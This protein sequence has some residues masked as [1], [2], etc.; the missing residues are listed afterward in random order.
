MEKYRILYLSNVMFA[1]AELYT[2]RLLHGLDRKKFK[3]FLAMTTP[4]RLPELIPKDVKYINV[5]I[6]NSTLRTAWKNCLII[7]RLYRFIRRYEID[8][9]STQNQGINSLYAQAAAR[10]GGIPAVETLQHSY[11]VR[12]RTDDFLIRNFWARFIRNSLVD[13]FVSL[14][15]YLREEQY[16]LWNVPQEKLFVNNMGVDIKEISPLGEESR[17]RV[18]KEFGLSNDNIILGFIGRPHPV[19]GLSKVFSLMS[20]LKNIIPE[21]RLLAVGVNI[22][23]LNYK[24]EVENSNIKENVVFCGPR[25]DVPRLISAMDMYIQAG[26]GPVL[27]N[28]TL[29]CLAGGKPNG[30]IIHSKEDKKK[31][32][33][34]VIEGENG[35][36]IDFN[37]LENEIPRLAALLQDKQLLA[38]MGERSRRLAEENFGQQEHVRNMERLYESLIMHHGLPTNT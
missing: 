16:Q 25:K 37:D 1:G 5:A 12:S 13:C 31:A 14:G 33:E 6:G 26:D 17:L 15:K 38:T 36:L 24:K 32:R 30:T 22:D 27:G 3:P 7:P 23:D 21:I 28:T 29:E 9:V 4:L 19:K 35:I 11:D 34:T 18:F 8:L 20:K 10:L 2:V